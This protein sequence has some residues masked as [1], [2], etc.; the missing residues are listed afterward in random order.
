M[1]DI[2]TDTEGIEHKLPVCD[3]YIYMYT[4]LGLGSMNVHTQRLSINKDLLNTNLYSI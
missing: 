3:I 2:L 4:A 1:I